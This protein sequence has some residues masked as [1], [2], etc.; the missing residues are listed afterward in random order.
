MAKLTSKQIE[1]TAEQV[2]RNDFDIFAQFAF[3]VTQPGVQYEWNWHIECISE[4]LEAMHR[5]E[6]SRLIINLPPRSLKSYL[7]SQA[8]PAWVLGKNPTEK[9]INISYGESVVEQNAMKCRAIIN[10]PMFKRI[11]PA[12][13]IGLLDRIKHFETS[14]KGHYYADSALSTVTGI[15]C[16]IGTTKIVTESGYRNIKDIQVDEYVWSYNHETEKRELQRVTATRSHKLSGLVQVKAISGR[17][18]LC[19]ANHLFWIDGQGYTQAKDINAGDKFIAAGLFQNKAHGLRP[20]MRL[21]HERIHQAKGRLSEMLAKGIYRTLLF[22]Q[23]LSPASQLQNTATLPHMP[24]T[25][26]IESKKILREMPRT[27]FFCHENGIFQTISRNKSPHR[28]SR[29]LSM[30]NMRKQNQ[31]P[32]PSFES[33]QNQQST[34][35]PNNDVSWM[36]SEASL[37]KIDYCL[38]VEK[39]SDAAHTVYDLRVERNSNFFAEGI[40]THNC[41]YMVIDDPLKPM[42]ALSDTVRN[43]TN[44]NIRSTLLNRFDDKRIGKLLMVMQRVHTDDPTG[45]L[46]KD[47]NIVHLKLPGETK[48]AIHVGLKTK[49][50]YR[51]WNMAENSLLFPARL[52]R[53]ILDQLRLD[54]T[55]YH[56]VGQ[57]LQ[58]PVPIGGGE[59]KDTWIQYYEGGAVFP[60]KM[61]I[62][63]LCDP[64]GGEELNKKKKKSSDW[65]AFMVVGASNDNNYYLLDIVRDRLNPTDRI[66]ALFTLHRKWNGLSGKPPK[67]GY[68]KYGLMSDTHYI[69]DKQKREGY[70]FQLIELGGQMLKEERIRRLIPDMQGG[71]WY[72]PV[73]LIYVDN[74][75]RKFDLVSELVNSEMKSFPRGRFDDMLDALSRIYDAELGMFFPRITAKSPMIVNMG[76]PDNDIPGWLDF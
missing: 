63:I 39:Y 7:V 2:A 48:T 16:F 1:E 53:D 61:N 13:K 14:M 70:H 6:I 25:D 40:L 44:E 15:G 24:S 28:L 29:W 26:C 65:T 3:P 50:G 54:M 9:F 45:N 57:I 41:N 75:G 19:T 35:K 68:E 5:G 49:E 56:Y 73:N 11:F 8:F 76:K 17:S 64:A 46:L 21:L 59:F 43:S 42:E 18:I 4:H 72:F 22:K 67:V 23:M 20:K 52:S 74:E 37:G 71:R 32:L 47:K 10:S 38:S 30:C 12:F 66:E 55:E 31:S 69:R 51:E 36:P 27:L 62:A 33:F 58:E 60:S 34:R